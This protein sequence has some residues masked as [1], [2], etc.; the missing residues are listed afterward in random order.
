MIIIGDV[1]AAIHEPSGCVRLQQD[2]DVIFF[3]RAE[4]AA[5]AAAFPVDKEEQA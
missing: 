3:T 1:E 2:D 5:L 4:I